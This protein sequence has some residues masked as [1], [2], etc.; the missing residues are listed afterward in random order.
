MMSSI[1][2]PRSGFCGKASVACEVPVNSRLFAKKRHLTF[3]YPTALES[4]T[5]TNCASN[6]NRGFSKNMGDQ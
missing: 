1:S 4:S 3:I 6:S 2:F 5:K